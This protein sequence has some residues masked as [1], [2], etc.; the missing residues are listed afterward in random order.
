MW[1]GALAAHGVRTTLVTARAWKGAAGLEGVPK[2]AARAAAVAELPAA[3]PLLA[4]KKDHGR[5]DALLIGLWRAKGGTGEHVEP[6]DSG[7]DG[8]CSSDGA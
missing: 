4:R 1:A 3:A 2:D 7:S 8:D 6:V 5:A